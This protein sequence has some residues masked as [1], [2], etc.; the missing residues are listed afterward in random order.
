MRCAVPGCDETGEVTWRGYSLCDICYAEAIDL[1]ED[2]GENELITT[3]ANT[4]GEE[5]AF[6]GPLAHE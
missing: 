2:I 1:P 5:Q 4:I 3:L 6:L